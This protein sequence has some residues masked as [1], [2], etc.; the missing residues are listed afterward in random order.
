MTPAPSA[1]VAWTLW[2]AMC[3]AL[4]NYVFVASVITRHPDVAGPELP[5]LTTVFAAVAA[6]NAACSLFLAP[7]LG[8][9]LRSY[10]VYLAARLLFAESIATLGLVLFILGADQAVFLAFA[11]TTLVL[12]VPAM[13]TERS[14][15]AFR[16]AGP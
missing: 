7:L 9:R 1:S 16:P 15:T 3:L 8:R 13:P 2:G 4:A 11:G 5:L 6:V 10:W 12:L 14:R